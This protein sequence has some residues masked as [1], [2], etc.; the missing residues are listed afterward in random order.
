MPDDSSLL[1]IRDLTERERVLFLTEL[2]AKRKDTAVA[3]LLCLFLG[4]FGAH[5]FYL[6]NRIL[7]VAYTCCFVPYWMVSVIVAFGIP[8]LIPFFVLVVEACF[9]SGRVRRYNGAVA[10]RIASGLK[11]L[12]AGADSARALDSA[13]HAAVPKVEASSASAR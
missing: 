1:A 8:L 6:G 12:R 2:N 11:S 4:G 7:A 3:V 13:D 9:L 5:H 10:Y